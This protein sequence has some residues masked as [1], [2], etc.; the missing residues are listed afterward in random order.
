VSSAQNG[1]LGQEQVEVESE[2]L[3]DAA[4]RQS[5]REYVPKMVL[6]ANQRRSL[7]DVRRRLLDEARMMGESG[8]YGWGNGKDKIEG[9]TIKL[10]NA[11]ARCW[12][13]CSV[14]SMPMQE[15]PDA[16]IFTS[17]FID[18][19]TGFTL[20]RQFRQSKN[21]MVYGKHDPERKAD[22]RFQIGQSKAAR[23]LILNA[24][25]EWL[26]DEAME[27]AK[28]GC[29]EKVE[30]LVNDKGIVH[31]VDIML[32]SLAKHGVTEEAVLLK[33]S[34][35]KKEGLK[36]DDIVM[37]RGCLQ[38][39]EDG[40]D[41]ADQ[42]FPGKAAETPAVRRNLRSTGPAQPETDAPPAD[43]PEK[44]SDA[45]AR[46]PWK[47]AIDKAVKTTNKQHLSSKLADIWDE[48]QHPDNPMSDD[49][50]A[51][52]QSYLEKAGLVFEKTASSELFEKGAPRQE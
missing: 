45:G 6:A 41:R 26:I 35:G 33:C 49:D 21:W 9:P 50:K 17:R 44:G 36:I 22:I 14:E 30:R 8:Y 38:A 48:C 27:V 25:P 52:V 3:L 15:T 31:A 39:I 2:S 5:V 23:N 37:L 34:V 51:W 12:G 47:A 7:P 18:L 13:N 24:L 29:R 20:E 16:Y 10:A 43:E 1:A 42:I 40:A 46:I 28:Q 32:R 11:A 19:E 4:I